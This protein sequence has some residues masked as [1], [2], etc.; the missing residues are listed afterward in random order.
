MCTAWPT[1]AACHLCVEENGKTT[2]AG[3]SYSSKRAIRS[4]PAAPSAV[5]INMQDLLT[6]PELALLASWKHRPNCAGQVGTMH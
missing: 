1:P 2:V 3:L 6:G 5:R 4:T